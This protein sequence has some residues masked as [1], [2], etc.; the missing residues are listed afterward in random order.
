MIEPRDGQPVSRR[1]E[2][3]LE[4]AEAVFLAEGFLHLSMDDLAR[5]L[6]CSK[7]TLY[8]LA[9]SHDDFIELVLRRYTERLHADMNRA[10]Q[11]APDWPGAVS[12]FL[13]SAAEGVRSASTQ[14]LRDVMTFPAGARAFAQARLERIGILRKLIEAGIRDGFFRHVD[15]HLVAEVMFAA[16]VRIS[17]PEFLSSTRLTWSQALRA[18]FRLITAGLMPRKTGDPHRARQVRS[19]TSPRSKGRRP[20]AARARRFRVPPAIMP[21]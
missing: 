3:I 14:F 19:A 10:A 12:A 5:R 2:R 4:E 20:R 6:R 21:A 11:T 16:A 18:L 7:R 9:P 13:D 15:A 1:A 17:D 8:E